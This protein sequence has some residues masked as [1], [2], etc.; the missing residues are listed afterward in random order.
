MLVPAVQPQGFCLPV[1]I[2]P[3]KHTMLLVGEDTTKTTHHGFMGSA[4]L[5]EIADTTDYKDTT[6]YSTTSK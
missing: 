5:Q 4:K 3:H 1:L 6:E 2:D